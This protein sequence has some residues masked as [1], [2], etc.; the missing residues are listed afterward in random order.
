VET[1]IYQ[2]NAVEAS[3][4]FDCMRQLLPSYP[5]I[6]ILE[7]LQNMYS[8]NLFSSLNQTIAAVRRVQPTA[9]IIFAVWLKPHL[10]QQP[11]MLQ[12][13]RTFARANGV[14][15][16]DAPAAMSSLGLHIS[17][18]YARAPNGQ[19]DHHPNGMGHELLGGLAAQCINRRLE[20]RDVVLS[21]IDELSE[22]TSASKE[23]S[24]TGRISAES[25]TPELCFSSADEM[26]VPSRSHS[27]FTLQ[28]DG[29]AK[30]VKKFGYSSKRLGDRLTIGPINLHAREGNGTQPGL[31]YENIRVRLGYLVST[32]HGMGELYITC[33]GG[34]GCRAVKSRYLQSV[35]PFPKLD[36]DA[37]HLKDWGLDSNE[38]V[39]M[40]AHTVF[41]AQLFNISAQKSTP[42]LAREVACYLD[43]S[44]RINSARISSPTSLSSDDSAP[45]SRVRVDSIALL[46]HGDRTKTVLC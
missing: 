28:D 19:I 22:D 18:V 10:V 8:M 40:T 45:A 25:Y 16:A 33:R 14:D 37:R 26:P 32:S 38:S 13:L 36:G 12:T 39:T 2:K 34:C 46:V 41:V 1:S 30:G 7:V 15:L 11:P 27:G 29:I 24:S 44:H 31:C 21:G 9:A 23:D 6:V 17:D 35:L 4:F 43:L 42:R 20:R 3:F 5:D